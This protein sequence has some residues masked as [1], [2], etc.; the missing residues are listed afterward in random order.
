MARDDAD[1]ESDIDLL[2]LVEGDSS[3]I[4]KKIIRDKEYVS[5]EDWA[6][7]RLEGGLNPL[8]CNTEELMNDYD[9]LL[10]NLLTE[11][12]RLYGQDLKGLESFIQKGNTTEK[13]NLLDL[14]RSL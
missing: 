5:L 14:V 1:F 4:F 3:E 2:F 13:N 11:G 9:S 12:I 10:S 7:E 6:L 8:V